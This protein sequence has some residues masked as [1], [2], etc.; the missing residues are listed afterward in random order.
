MK[1]SAILLWVILAALAAS[2]AFFMIR[3]ARA[4]VGSGFEKVLIPEVV[5]RGL[6]VEAIRY[7]C[8]W[9]LE[10]AELFLAASADDVSHFSIPKDDDGFYI[11]VRIGTETTGAIFQHTVVRFQDH[12]VILTPDLAWLCKVERDESSGHYSMRIIR[13][14]NQP[15][16]AV[17]RSRLLV[18]SPAFAG[19]APSNRLAHF[20]R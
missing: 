1:S 18:T 13:K 14:E 12:V 11:T 17:E 15:N 3:S 2:G 9:R 7:I 5:H 6:S 4:T 20:G 10:D 8:S 16:K 19:L